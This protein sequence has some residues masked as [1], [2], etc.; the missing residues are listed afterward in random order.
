MMKQKLMLALIAVLPFSACRIKK[1]DT[2]VD[3]TPTTVTKSIDVVQPPQEKQVVDLSDNT[4]KTIRSREKLRTEEDKYKKDSSHTQM[5]YTLG[6]AAGVGGYVSRSPWPQLPSELN[7]EE[8]DSLTENTFHE[9]AKKPLST[10]SIDV[11]AASYA[12]TR[13]FL[14]SNQLPPKDAVRIEE[15]I[16]YFPYAYKDPRGEDPVSINT[17]VANCPWNNEHRLVRIGLKGREIKTEKL[18]VSNLVFLIDVSGSMQDANKLP[19]LK[20]AFRLLVKELRS[21]DTVSLVV[22]AGNAGL[23]LPPTEGSEK[24]KILEAIDRLQAGGSTSGG[25]GIQLAYDIAKRNF[26]RNG[27]NRVILA[28]DGDFNVGV[29]SDGELVRLI[30][31]KRQHGIFLTVLGFGLGNYKDS[32]MEKLADKGNGNYAYIDNLLEAKKVLVSEMGATLHTIAK[33]VKI[34]VEFNPARVQSY[35]LIGYENR[36]LNDE[37]FNNDKKDAGEMGAG[38]TVTALYEVVPV[39]VSFQGESIDPLKYQAVK[40][41]PNTS[42]SDELLTVKFRYKE[43]QGSISKMVSMVVVDKKRSLAQTS[44]DF[45]FVSAVA[46]FG[47]LLRNSEFKNDLTYEQVITLAKNSM[48]EDPEGYRAEFLKLVKTAHAIST[49]QAF[50]D[51]YSPQCGNE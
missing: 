8:Y 43:P 36:L 24:E 35:R 27:N 49:S 23:V 5:A 39:G 48:G 38:S 9:A 51:Q 31:E 17:E 12:N 15:F 16:N 10:F 4:Q 19:L 25:A 14:N 41:L 45:Q 32:K 29:S 40:L 21:N 37:D 30:E 11:D 28:T 46:G 44:E 22:Y 33:D 50:I 3:A 1:T 34:Q 42:E 6:E 47:M 7:T 26:M 2:R 18:P 20:S 13:R